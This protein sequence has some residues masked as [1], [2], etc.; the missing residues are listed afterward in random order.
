MQNINFCVGEHFSLTKMLHPA[1]SCDIWCWSNSRMSAQV[2]LGLVA[3]KGKLMCRTM[4]VQFYQ[5]NHFVWINKSHC[6]LHILLVLGEQKQINKLHAKGQVCCCELSFSLSEWVNIF[7]FCC[8]YLNWPPEGS[9]SN[10]IMSGCLI[11]ASPSQLSV[12]VRVCASMC[13][14]SCYVSPRIKLGVSLPLTAC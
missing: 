4:N 12:C 7:L 8:A 11:I 5:T 10:I 2:C 1:G 13:V 6:I 9:V 14:K 3:I